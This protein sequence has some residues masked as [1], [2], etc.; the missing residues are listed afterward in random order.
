MEQAEYRRERCGTGIAIQR[1]VTDMKKILLIDDEELVRQA[2]VYLL[3]HLKYETV[4]APTGMNGIQIAQDLR[5]DLILCD[6]NMPGMDGHSVL[7]ALRGDPMT[8]SIPFIFLTGQGEKDAFRRG[9]NSGADDYLTKPVSMEE[10]KNAIESRLSRHADIAE[11]YAHEL[12]V[13]EEKMNKLI[14]Y[15]A[16]TEFPNRM[17][18][19]E[20]MQQ[21][22]QSGSTSIGIL[23]LS[24]DR[25]KRVN[26]SLG[27]YEGDF[28]LTLLAER[29]RKELKLKHSVARISQDEFAIFARGEKHHVEKIAHRLLQCVEKPFPLRTH[30]I[31]VTASIG[32]AMYPEGGAQIDQLLKKA[33]TATEVARQKG[34]NQY[35]FSSDCPEVFIAENFLLESELRMA[36]ERAELD[37][38]YQPQIDVSCG[39]IIGAEALVRWPHT[40]KGMISPMRF[41][42]V[43]EETGLI[44]QLGEW[45]LRKACTDMNRLFCP[46][47]PFRIAVNLSGSQFNRPE[48]MGRLIQILKE[49]RTDPRNLEFEITESVLIEQPDAAL[50]RMKELKRLG[51]TL[52]LDDFGTGYSSFA[53]LKQ[54]P[55]DIVKIDRSFI[56]NVHRDPKSS[57]I[58]TAII[59]MARSLNLKIIA[60]GVETLSEYEFLKN[61]GCDEVQGYLF[62]PAVPSSKFS[63]LL[64]KPANSL[65][66]VR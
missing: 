22:V 52:S 38:H 58:V 46:G 3:Q 28:M 64:M 12:Q 21:A 34:G 65:L 41:I 40:T 36:M 59:Q 13:V 29:L 43:A 37:V 56:Q 6:V 17:M 48:L 14:Y 11:Q 26:G 30:E 39:S 10:L 20:I 60:E 16:L 62:S 23:C 57:A 49:T 55:F 63:E 42:P 25:F 35:V 31:S 54:F 19:S 44:L 53:Y 4:G 33:S 45:I 9:M 32:I 51:V 18:V 15:D 5:P 27:Y 7:K 61:H 2:M 24:L 66:N 8:R 1:D 50:K 47:S